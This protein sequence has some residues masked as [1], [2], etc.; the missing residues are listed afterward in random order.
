[1]ANGK[2]ATRTSIGVSEGAG[3]VTLRKHGEETLLKAG[4]VQRAIFNSAKSN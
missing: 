1:M 2:D 3:H 4:A